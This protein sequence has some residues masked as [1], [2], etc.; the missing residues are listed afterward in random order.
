MNY[1][2][3]SDADSHEG[4]WTNTCPKGTKENIYRKMVISNEYFYVD[5]DE[6]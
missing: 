5:L 4:V 6:E 3:I 2:G 1:E